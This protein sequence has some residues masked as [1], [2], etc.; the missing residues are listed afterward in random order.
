MTT[1]RSHKRRGRSFESDVTRTLRDAGYRAER[2]PLA[3]RNDEGDVV[4]EFPHD[5]ELVE[6]KAPGRD[7][8]IDLAGW[9]REA[10]TEAK[11]WALAR[12]IRPESVT[13]FVVIK[14]RGKPISDA[15]V[16]QRFHQAWPLDDG[17]AA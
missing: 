3:G 15:Y 2:V 11:N 6:C 5:W 8:K 12:G 17:G 1:Q 9:M 7:G 14:A 16:V 10:E 4:V 13:P